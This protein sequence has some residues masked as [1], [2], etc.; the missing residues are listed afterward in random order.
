MSDDIDAFV[1][2]IQEMMLEEAKQRFGDIAFERWQNPLY[3]GVMPDADTAAHVTGSCGDS[4]TAYMK[5]ENG[6]VRETAFQTDGCAPTIICG[7]FAAE[8]ALNKT[9][10]EVMDIS[11]EDVM[12]QF[13]GLPE[14]HH[15]CATLAAGAFY[16]AVHRYM[17]KQAREG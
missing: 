3:M 14:E 9:L 8:L 12:A 17:V 16:E 5:F 7:S 2:Q 15:H 10:D 4:M 13:G 1:K 11:G 6:R